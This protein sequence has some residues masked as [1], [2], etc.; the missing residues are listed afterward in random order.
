MERT[1]LHVIDEVLS[2]LAEESQLY[3]AEVERAHDVVRCILARQISVGWLEQPARVLEDEG[4]DV[5]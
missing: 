5:D 2:S 1:W 4:D 3:T